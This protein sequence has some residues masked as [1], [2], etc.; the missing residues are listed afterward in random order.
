MKNQ[1]RLHHTQLFLLP[2]G[3]RQRSPSAGSLINDFL[4]SVIDLANSTDPAPPTT[5]LTPP[6]RTGEETDERKEKVQVVVCQRI[7]STTPSHVT[8]KQPESFTVY[9]DAFGEFKSASAQNVSSLYRKPRK[10]IC[11]ANIGRIPKLI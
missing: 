1:A 10:Q 11:M 2:R 3:Q 5:T 9:A 8:S 4:C 6:R 7:W